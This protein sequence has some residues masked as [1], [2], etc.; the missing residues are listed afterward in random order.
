MFDPLGWESAMTDVPLIDALLLWDGKGS[1]REP[2]FV[3][4]PLG[5]DDYWAYSGQSGACFAKWRAMSDNDRRMALLLAA[6]E[7]ATFYELPSDL[8][9]KGMLVI[10]EYREMVAGEK[11]PMQLS[12]FME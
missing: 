5:H 7:I 10:P 4:R 3:V 1:Q 9:N 8:I 2:G 11:L 12:G 6:W